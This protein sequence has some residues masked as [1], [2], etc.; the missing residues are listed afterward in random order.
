MDANVQ[1]MRDTVERRRTQNRLAQRKF[2]EKKRKG[3][4]NAV[5]ETSQNPNGAIRALSQATSTASINGD[6]P[7]SSLP[8]FPSAL[9]TQ[10]GAL[11]PNEIPIASTEPEP[12]VNFDLDAIDQFWYQTNND[13]SF[14]LSDPSPVQSSLAQT[15]FTKNKSPGPALR[16]APSDTTTSDN[17]RSHS[18]PGD[19]H[20]LTLYR[21]TSYSDILPESPAPQLP[22]SYNDDTVLELITSARNDKGWISTLHIAAQK[23]H[24]RIVRVLLLRGSMDANKQDSDGRTPL[25]HAVIENHD[26]VVRL[27]LSHGARIGVYDC[28]G[29]SALHWAVLHQ[30]LDILQLLLEHRTKYERSL[31]LDVY[32]NTGW[33]PLHMAV[34]RAFEAGVL[35]LL[36]EGADINAKAHK[37]PYIGKVMPMMD[38]QR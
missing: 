24:E 29:R 33:T 8:S 34:D 26:S 6:F 25:I 17:S 31:D 36:Q 9:P 14:P 18:R 15:N 35:M 19:N 30:R 16:K 11:S 22:Q 12:V 5:L 2:R 3:A 13:F 32:D 7:I 20:N 10:A 23:G 37:C 28:D 21:R 27:L 4:E 1:F 38:R